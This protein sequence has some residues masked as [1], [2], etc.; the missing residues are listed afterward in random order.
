MAD[1]SSSLERWSPV[2][3]LRMVIAVVWFLILLALDLLVGDQVVDFL[4]DVLSGFAVVNS[5]VV[6]GLALVTR[7]GTVAVMIAGAVMAVR[8]SRGRFLLTGLAGG[9]VGALLL[10]IVD[11]IFDVSAPPVLVSDD[12]LGW[13]GRGSYPTTVGLAAL[14]GLIAA[15]VPWLARRWRRLGWTLVVLLAIERAFTAPLSFH[16]AV[17]VVCGAFAGALADAALGTPTRRPT[18]AAVIEGLTRSGVHLADLDAAAVDARGSTP[19]F[20]HTEDGTRLFVKALGA[21]ER[22]A[23]LLFRLVRSIQPRDLGDERPFSS[24]R[25]AVEHEAF[26]ALAADQSGV[27]TPP[28]VA[29]AGAEPG[30]YVLAYEAIAGKSL[31]GVEPEGLTDEV[32]AGI[33]DQMAILRSHGI[34]HRDLRLANVFLAE[35]GVVWLIDFGFSEVAASDL[36]LRTDL[37]ELVTSLSLKVGADRAVD[38]A[39]A[40]IGAGELQAALPRFS[41][42]FLSGATRTALKERPNHLDEVRQRIEG[43]QVPA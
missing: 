3:A 6:T 35:D 41:P 43:L 2:D 16:T 30:G 36:L 40:A 7:V 8:G 21:D 37:A 1:D 11:P 29:F 4:S 19:Y 26:V 10:W 17:A 32:L 18:K 14:T 22:K 31:D 27:R 39:A 38:I 33:W 5:H 23:D 15:G 28:L 20:G 13:L 25:R 34:A 12:V 42:G 24:L 9:A